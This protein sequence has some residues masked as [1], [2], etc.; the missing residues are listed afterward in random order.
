LLSRR[1]RSLP[2]NASGLDTHRDSIKQLMLPI[3][4]QRRATLSRAFRVELDHREKDGSMAKD[5]THDTF[6]E[7]HPIH[8][9]C[10]AS[11]RVI[12]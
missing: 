5:T 6:P 1:G 8:Q 3:L 12:S 7:K 10:S 4:N 2:A 11:R 9:V